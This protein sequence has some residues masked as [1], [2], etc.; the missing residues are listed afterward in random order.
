MIHSGLYRYPW[1]IVTEAGFSVPG[2]R[3]QPAGSATTMP[4]EY[5]LV[6]RNAQRHGAEERAIVIRAERRRQLKR[7]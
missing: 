3:Q 2:I 4:S 6:H 7:Q 5:Q 1:F